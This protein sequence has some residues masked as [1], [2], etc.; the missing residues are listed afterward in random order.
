MTTLTRHDTANCGLCKRIAAGETHVLKGIGKGN[1]IPAFCVRCDAHH[2]GEYHRTDLRPG[3]KKSLCPRCRL[4][5]REVE[6][7]QHAF[8][9]DRKHYADYCAPCLEDEGYVYYQ[10]T[11]EIGW[12]EKRSSVPVPEISDAEL[13]EL[14]K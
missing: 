2:Y 6:H 9:A 7:I 10:A 14:F 1:V 13:W 8:R 11:D 5:R 12:W 4:N 3:D